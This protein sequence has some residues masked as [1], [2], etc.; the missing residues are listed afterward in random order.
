[1]IRSLPRHPFE[2]A[3]AGTF[4]PATSRVAGW[5]VQMSNLYRHN[6]SAETRSI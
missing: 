2:C 1:M 6:E 3:C 5:V 4:R